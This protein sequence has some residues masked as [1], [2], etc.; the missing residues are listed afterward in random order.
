MMPGV[1]QFLHKA[2]INFCT[3]FRTLDVSDAVAV[4]VA[5]GLGVDLAGDLAVF[6]NNLG[7][8]V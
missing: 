3:S 7:H 6:R 2:Y 5:E 8:A 1:A 4:G